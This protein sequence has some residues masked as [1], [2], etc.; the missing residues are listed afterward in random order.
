MFM[1]DDSIFMSIM[2]CAYLLQNSTQARTISAVAQKHV[3]TCSRFSP[4][5]F[6]NQKI[7]LLYLKKKSGATTVSAEK[8]Y[9]PYNK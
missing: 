6:A 8:V 1:Q 7:K 5:I 3:Q 4:R 9:Q 2:T